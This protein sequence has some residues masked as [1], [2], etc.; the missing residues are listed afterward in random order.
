MGAFAQVSTIAG[1]ADEFRGALAY[2]LGEEAR[3]R[4]EVPPDLLTERCVGARR[5][6]A[7]SEGLSMADAVRALGLLRWGVAAGIEPALELRQVDYALCVTEF[8]AA[9][10]PAIRA[11]NLRH[12]LNLT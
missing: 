12:D 3:A 11:E 9:N 2:L 4:Q 5:F 6:L 10:D 7:Q 1:N 8:R